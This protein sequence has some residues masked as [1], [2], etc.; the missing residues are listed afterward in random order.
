MKEYVESFDSEM[1]R[2]K[3]DKEMIAQETQIC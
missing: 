3:L 1:K 2:N